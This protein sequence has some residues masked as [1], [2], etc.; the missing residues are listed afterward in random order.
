MRKLVYILLL[1][2]LSVGV[3]A[4]SFRRDWFLLYNGGDSVD[5]QH[6]DSIIAYRANPGLA[7]GEMSPDMSIIKPINPDFKWLV[8]VSAEDNYVPR[9][10]YPDT[11][12]Y[13]YLLTMADDSGWSREIF[14]CHYQDT[15]IVTLGGD[16]V[17]MPAYAYAQTQQ[18]SV[19]ARCYIYYSDRS[20]VLKNYSNQHSREAHVAYL[21]YYLN[22]PSSGGYY[23]D[24]IFG[25]NGSYH[26]WNTGTL[27]K[28]GHIYEAGGLR[29][30]SVGII[31]QI[32][33]GSLI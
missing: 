29:V 19:D 22:Q 6:N 17:I 3:N 31:P 32:G 14:Y 12:E 1:F 25:D 9:T 18:D 16:S 13:H 7:I 27:L 26:L 10:C 33:G 20:R 8:Y 24:G 2:S 15:T 4:T 23:H 11:A 21:K 28:G 5:R 30:D